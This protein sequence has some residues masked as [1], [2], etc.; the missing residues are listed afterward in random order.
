MVHLF[1][2]AAVVAI[3]DSVWLCVNKKTTCSTKLMVFT[4]GWHSEHREILH[5]L[6]A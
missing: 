1:T 4:S 5:Y 2:D 3:D 6:F